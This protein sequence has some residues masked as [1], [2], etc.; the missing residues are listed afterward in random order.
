[1]RIWDQRRL[2]IPLT[3]F[4]EHPFQNWTRSS[5]E[6]LGTV[7]L[8]VDY[9]VPVDD[10]RSEL[11]N[12]LDST[13]LWDGRVW[14]LHVTD[15]KERAVELRALVSAKNSS[16]AWDLRCLVRERLIRFVQERYPEAL[17]RMRAEVS[18]VPTEE[19]LERSSV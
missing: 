15:A 18:M 8:H 17:P 7:F 5:S 1:M 3:Y 2:V 12:I 13:D 16:D 9:S 6:I 14:R 4:I 11:K 10:L 19:M